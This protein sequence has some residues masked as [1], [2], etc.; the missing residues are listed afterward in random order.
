MA[1]FEKWIR[2]EGMTL[3]VNIGVHD[4]EKKGPQPYKIDIGLKLV[5]DYFVRTE[6]LSETVDYDRLRNG[7]MDVFRDRHINLQETAIQEIVSL[8][9]ALDQRV[10]E[11]DVSLAKT[12]VYD[13]CKSVGLHY[14]VN[15]ED[16][17]KQFG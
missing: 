10:T 9:F 11:A 2:L 7:V 15:R 17:S 14:L 8:C 4:F 5:D 3:D 6:S 12:N 13:N 1:L 16:W